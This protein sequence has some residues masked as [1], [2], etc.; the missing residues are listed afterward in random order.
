[1]TATPCAFGM[2]SCFFVVNASGMMNFES[3]LQ[4]VVAQGLVNRRYGASVYI[5][6]IPRLPGMVG[7]EWFPGTGCSD[8]AGIRERWL[9]TLVASSGR[10]A[11]PITSS[12]FLMLVQA[13]SL[14]AGGALY[15]S[16][17]LHSLGPVLT[18]CGVHALLPASSAAGLPRGLEV[19][20]DGRHRWPDATAA[21]WFVGK[22]LLPLTNRSTLALQAPTEL[23][24]L[25]DAIVAWRLPMVWMDD[26]CHDAAQNAALRYVLEGS[27]HYRDAPIVQY[28]GWFNH[29]RLPNTELVCQ[30][31]AS[32][33]IITIASDWAE[34]LSFL[35]QL[36]PSRGAPAEPWV[37]PDDAV[38][39]HGGYSAEH[40]YVAI[41]VSDGDNLAQD[42]WNLRPVLERR[43]ALKSRV[44]VSWTVSNRWREFGRPV[45]E[46][47]YSAAA[48]TGGYDSFLMGPSGF[49]YLFPGAIEANASRLEFGRRTAEAAHALGM[50]AY[51]HWDV[52][53]RMDP[54]TTRRTTA[55]VAMYNGSAIRGVFM[56][57][58]DP[59]ADTVGDV[60]VINH[61]AL[62]WGWENATAA[63]K[64]LN[65]LP[66]GTITYVYA[67]MKADIAA[68]DALAAALESH[69]KLLGHRELIRVAQMKAARR[70]S[71]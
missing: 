50:Q 10:R 4:L 40:T 8:C 49:G 41:V 28:V 13:H 7:I 23:P 64:T 44:P 16:Q 63:A 46:W 56:L 2:P 54:S 26:M 55:A 39:V 3:A 14:V 61:P 60:V 12:D 20:F 29:T 1:M 65:G 66:R 11:V 31:T 69:V 22:R 27:S 17:E 59:I 33:R 71:I 42:M 48:S 53:R 67:N 45:L 70:K 62:P 38:K 58:S 36:N 52:D 43:L 35:S 24:F 5:I 15:S 47:F 6:G 25:A 21:A 19:R 68:P 34:N 57:G 37:Q 32:K 9:A 51:V 18:V 30:C